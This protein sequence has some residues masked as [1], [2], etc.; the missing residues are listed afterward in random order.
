MS[1]TEDD[2]GKENVPKGNIPVYIVLGHTVKS[3]M[4]VIIQDGELSFVMQIQKP[5]ILGRLSL[6]CESKSQKMFPTVC[7]KEEEQLWQF[8]KEQEWQS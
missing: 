5:T 4:T 3:C 2:Y 7:Q 1:G 6:V 8:L